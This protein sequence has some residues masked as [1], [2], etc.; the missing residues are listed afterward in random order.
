MAEQNKPIDW[1]P[2]IPYRN[3]PN[4]KGIRRWWDETFFPFP[5]GWVGNQYVDLD[6]VLSEEGGVQVALTPARKKQFISSIYNKRKEN[7]KRIEKR[8]L[9]AA[10]PLNW[11]T[12]QMIG[13]FGSEL[14]KRAIKRLIG[15]QY[16]NLSPDQIAELGG[17]KNRIT[18]REAEKLFKKQ[19]DEFRKFNPKEI[20][21]KGTSSITSNKS[22]VIPESV[23]SKEDK[24]VDKVN[25]VSGESIFAPGKESTF[26]WDMPISNLNPGFDYNKIPALNI[27]WDPQSKSDIPWNDLPLELPIEDSLEEW[28]EYFR[29]MDQ[30]SLEMRGE[31]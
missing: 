20:H 2:R 16:A 27:P 21:E 5:K 8:D 15:G 26:Q 29:G 11:A 9:Q 10:N 17:K 4:T 18:N 24:I 22:N 31:L 6:P 12:P 14:N 30:L 28:P 1:Q 7:Y 13:M 23:K 3:I 25:Q 19:E